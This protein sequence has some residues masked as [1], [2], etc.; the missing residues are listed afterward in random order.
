MSSTFSFLDKET[1]V[2]L[3]G[4]CTR[5]WGSLLARRED[6]GG[7]TGIRR[8]VCGTKTEGEKARDEFNE[9]QDR[10]ALNLMNMQSG[11]APEYGDAKFVQKIFP[12][13][14]SLSEA[15]LAARVQTKLPEG[16]MRNRLNRHDFP[17]GSPGLLFIQAHI[18][19]AGVAE[20]SYPDEM[21][22]AHM[23]DVQVKDD[24]FLAFPLSIEGFRDDPNYSG[25]RLKNRMGSTLIEAM[26]A[27][28]ACELA[29]KAI[30][31]TCGD[32]AAKTHD[33]IELHDDLPEPGR[34]RI[35]ADYPEIA[36][37]LQAA[38]HTFGQWRY[39]EVN[40]GEAGMRAMIDVPHAHALG[41]A[42]RVILDEAVMVGLGAAVDMETKDNVRIVGNTENHRFDFKVSIKARETPPRTGR[43]PTG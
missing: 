21:S 36:E 14:D 30:C 3:K 17:L 9:M 6:N 27:A 26:T 31:L 18:L 19:M 39:F 37:T 8:R 34:R 10:T 11:R 4:R 15:E 32:E 29:M 13:P 38:R 1:K 43:L 40:V 2:K 33:L 24:G 28:F 7:W 5:C 20:I 42:A 23:P 16:K 22:V 41:K 25:N 35:A 12:E